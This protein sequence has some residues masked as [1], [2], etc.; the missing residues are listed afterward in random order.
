M[1]VC[2]YIYD[3][4]L[5]QLGLKCVFGIVVIKFVVVSDVLGNKWEEVFVDIIEK[6]SVMFNVSVSIVGV[7]FF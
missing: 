2:V 5:L 7:C 4:W 3:M 6:I 1:Q